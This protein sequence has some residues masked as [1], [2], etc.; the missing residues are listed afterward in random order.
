[1]EKIKDSFLSADQETKINVIYWLPEQKPQAILQIAHGMIEFCDR[2]DEMARWF[3]QH[4]FLVLANDHLGHGDS[5]KGQEDWGFFAQ[6]DGW[7]KVLLDMHHLKESCAEKYPNLPYFLL[8]HSMGSFLLRNYLFLWPKDQLA[9]AILVGTGQNSGP[10]LAGGKFLAASLVKIKGARER[11]K[12]LQDIALGSNN[13]AFE[14]ARTRNDWLTRDEAIVD[15]Y[16]QDPRNNFTFTNQAFLD[17][18]GGLQAINKKSNLQK[19]NKKLPLLF[20]S[21]GSDPV[22]NMGKGVK[23]AYDLYLDLGMEEL[24]LKIYP[25]GRHEIL[26]EINRQEVYS[27]LL[28]WLEDKI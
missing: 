22:G 2:Y 1:M 27:D 28:H 3:C 15:L 10:M 14:P 17:M 23:K 18:F 21:G 19:M 26:N 7:H 9:G 24:D 11:G 5:I 8:G 4:G 16:N 13:K 25:E 6:E 12:I 20:I